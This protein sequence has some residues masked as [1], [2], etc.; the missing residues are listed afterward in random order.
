MI[1]RMT[2]AAAGAL[3]DR[4]DADA[5]FDE[6]AFDDGGMEEGSAEPVFDFSTYDALDDALLA[7]VI[8]QVTWSGAEPDLEDGRHRHC[9]A[10]AGH[11]LTGLW[12]EDVS[13]VPGEPFGPPAAALGVFIEVD[14][15][16]RSKIGLYYVATG[17]GISTPEYRSQL[18]RSRA[19]AR[20]AV[21]SLF[22]EEAARDAE[23][24]FDLLHRSPRST[25]RP[26][27]LE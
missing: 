16:A 18:R 9:L 23:Q 11:A 13:V 12:E 8:F 20:R 26:A 2:T 14:R 10:A 22:G 7:G 17:Q 25:T 4:V 15:F 6:P 21:A 5:D 27:R 19:A 1:D 24:E 3:Q